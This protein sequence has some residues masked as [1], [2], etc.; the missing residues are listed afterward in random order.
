MTTINLSEKK[1]LIQN[2]GKELF[3]RITNLPQ[4]IRSDEK[5]RT[6]IQIVARE[7]GTRNIVMVSIYEPSEAAR[8]F[9]VEKTVRTECKEQLTSQDSE[10]PEFMQFAGSIIYICE[11]SDERFHTSVSGLKAEED[12]LVSIIILSRIIEKSSKEIIKKIKDWK[13][14]RISVGNLPNQLFDENHYLNTILNEYE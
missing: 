3:D 4:E 7:E 10:D 11:D 12:V 8:F 13:M 6:G 14:G 2:L 9:A 5:A 1:E